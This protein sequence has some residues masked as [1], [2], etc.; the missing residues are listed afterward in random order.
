MSNLRQLTAS[1]KV[2]N[3]N[4]ETICRKRMTSDSYAEDVSPVA[5]RTRDAKPRTGK[6]TSKAAAWSSS[7]MASKAKGKRVVTGSASIASWLG[8]AKASTPVAK[9]LV[10]KVIQSSDNLVGVGP[11][12][13]SNKFPESICSSQ[14][15]IGRAKSSKSRTAT[16]KCSKFKVDK[17]DEVVLDKAPINCVSPVVKTVQPEPTVAAP[18]LVPVAV[19][20]LSGEI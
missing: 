4:V 9:S 1:Q 15:P 2:T 5:K 12:P 16:M 6:V 19:Q 14:R 7:D 18:I 17:L 13:P 3:L 8:T 20:E 11:S 10:S